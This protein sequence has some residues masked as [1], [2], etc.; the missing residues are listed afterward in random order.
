MDRFERFAEAFGDT[1]GVLEDA[2][3][4]SRATLVDKLGDNELA[5]AIHKLSGVY[6]GATRYKKQQRM[7]RDAVA[8]NKH[9]LGTLKV[10]ERYARKVSDK[11][12][13]KMRR[14][15]ARI[16]GGLSTIRAAART[17][18]AKFNG[19]TGDKPARTQASMSN[20]SDR[21]DRTIHLTGPEAAIAEIWERGRD[22]AASTGQSVAEAL[23][24]LFNSGGGKTKYTPMVIVSIGDLQAIHA[25]GGAD[26]DVILSATNGARIPGKDFLDL[27][28]TEHGYFMLTSRVSGPVDLY[29]TERFFSTKQRT[30]A[31][32]CDP[33]CSIPGCG[34]P[35]DRCEPNH[36]RAWS[37]GGDTNVSNASMLC[38][39][40]NGK[41]DDDRSKRRFGY[42][43][44][45]NGHSKYFSAFG[46][47][48]RRNE[49]PTAR[50]GALRIA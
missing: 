14:E 24:D 37:A 48:P 31:K 23:L 21:L 6:F 27:E 9:S 45:V 17:L 25:S 32:A 13:W 44:R 16:R 39:Y 11:H 50:G 3:G 47:P 20:P 33:V 40:H 1:L 10:I 43:E 28:L 26:A 42:V 12:A 46:G 2:Q 7:A 22:H 4:L 5:G 19:D 41:V 35:A 15:L 8:T 29:R 34:Q 49:H 38:R 18:V 36:N 30:M